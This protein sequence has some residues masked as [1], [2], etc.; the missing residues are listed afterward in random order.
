VTQEYNFSGAKFEYLNL[1]SLVNIYQNRLINI[2]PEPS[3][4]Y[5]LIIS[6]I[7]LIVFECLAYKNTQAPTIDI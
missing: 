6:N 1:Q 2:L 4:V 3:F 5:Y 7:Y